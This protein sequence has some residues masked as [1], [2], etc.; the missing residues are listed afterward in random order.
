G[1]S[2][3]RSVGVRGGPGATT[4]AAPRGVDLRDA[5]PAEPAWPFR[6]IP[7]RTGGPPGDTPAAVPSDPAGRAGA[8]PGARVSGP[9]G[10]AVPII[11]HVPPDSLEAALRR[12]DGY[13]LTEYRADVGARYEAGAGKL[14]LSGSPSLAREGQVIRSDSLLVYDEPRAILCAYGKPVLEGANS[15]PVESQQVCYAVDQRLGVAL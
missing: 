9:P 8:A 13:V 2:A 4:R 5:R 14:E 12:M 1:L 10:R 3:R 11:V 7:G 15:A 6:T